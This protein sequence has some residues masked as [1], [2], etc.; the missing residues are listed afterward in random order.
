VKFQAIGIV[1]AAFTSI[2][3]LGV[4]GLS[5]AESG[6]FTKRAT[7]DVKAARIET[8]ALTSTSM[9]RGELRTNI[10]SGGG[11]KYNITW[12]PGT[13]NMTVRFAGASKDANLSILQPTHEI[14][15]P[16]TQTEVDSFIC[17]ETLENPSSN[18][19]DNGDGVEDRLLRIRADGCG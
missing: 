17:F 16:T 4:L 7:L 12:N 5:A 9:E 10:S 11:N 13:G 3:L 8:A 18:A 2:V 14:D 1:E 15:A 19:D 6:Q